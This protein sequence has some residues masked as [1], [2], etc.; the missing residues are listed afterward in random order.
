VY[1]LA[2]NIVLLGAPGVGKGTVAQALE[3]RF[4]LPH[5]SSGDLLRLKAQ[6]DSPESI[7]L[8][9]IMKSGRL[10]GDEI[11]SKIISER[12]SQ[13]DCEKGFILDGFPRTVPQIYILDEIL[14][15]LGKSVS[16]V[17]EIRAPK[18]IIIERL[19]GRRQCKKCG[20]IYN[21][22]GNMP[23]NPE[24]CDNCGGEVVQ[25]SDDMPETIEKRIDV[26][27]TQ[28]RPIID[29]YKKRGILYT[30]DCS[31]QDFEENLKSVLKAIGEKLSPL[32]KGLK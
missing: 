30:A 29:I 13:K 31:S 9:N 6:G 8:R 4:G 32:E 26:Y 16:I 21:L 11:I 3:K 19:S 12:V 2:I 28:T 7:E 25:R 24:I 27:N 23:T 1:F 10:V 5:I 17:L 15:K 18:H 14:K 22:N 20:T